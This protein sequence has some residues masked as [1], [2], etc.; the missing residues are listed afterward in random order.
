MNTVPKRVWV[1]LAVSV[2][3]NMFCLGV[4]ASRHMGMRGRMPHA[5]GARAFMHRSGL[6]S[7]G[8]DVQAILKEQ[9]E[10]VHQRMHALG[11]SR[12]RVREALKA[13]PY[14]A[15]RVDAAFG[16]VRE[17]TSAMQ[18]Q[19]HGVLSKVASKLSPDQ[20]KRLAGALWGPRGDDVAP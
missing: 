1:V 19:M 16:D 9:R 20:R 4:F 11:E 18:A 10:G 17:Q 12:K 15:A 6:H 8:P 3:L 13:E 7:A 2:A 14:D 5:M